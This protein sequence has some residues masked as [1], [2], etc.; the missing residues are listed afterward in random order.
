MSIL[1]LSS[2]AVNLE[3]VT[4]FPP[5]ST[6]TPVAFCVAL[7]GSQRILVF[8]WS[9]LT[10]GDH[11]HLNNEEGVFLFDVPFFIKW[12]RSGRN[13]NSQ[14]GRKRDY[15]FTTVR[16]KLV[17]SLLDLQEQVFEP[18]KVTGHYYL[19]EC[20]ICWGIKDGQERIVVC[21]QK[22]S[23]ERGRMTSKNLKK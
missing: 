7:C 9:T 5:F 4:C 1:V 21:Y 19:T 10:M 23:S 22:S 2:C 8:Y 11:N 20:N 13:Y 6:P 17:Y 12:N 16:K 3:S 18:V 14:R 15:P